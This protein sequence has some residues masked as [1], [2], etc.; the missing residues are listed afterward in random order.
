MSRMSYLASSEILKSEAK[1]VSC[2]LVICT[3]YYYLLV[4]V[5]L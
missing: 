1:T 4:V 2:L 3:D 5:D